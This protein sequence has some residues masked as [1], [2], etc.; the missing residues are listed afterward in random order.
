MKI[1]GHSSFDERT[2]LRV[3][4]SDRPLLSRRILPRFP[5]DDGHWRLKIEI[6]AIKAKNVKF[7]IS[8]KNWR[9]DLKSLRIT[10]VPLSSFPLHGER[11]VLTGERTKRDT[12]E[13][14]L[15]GSQSSFYQR[16]AKNQDC[17]LAVRESLHLMMKELLTR[18]HTPCTLSLKEKA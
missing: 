2:L 6:E 7:I 10:T 11:S 13:L 16:C 4:R 15:G 12:R 17:Y 8:C 3:S 9:A 18:N 1:A 5:C 14:Y